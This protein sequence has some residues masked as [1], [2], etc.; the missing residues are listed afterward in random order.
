MLMMSCSRGV[1]L[2]SSERRKEEEEEEEG[3]EL[4][5]NPLFFFLPLPRPPQGDCTAHTNHQTHAA[6]VERTANHTHIYIPSA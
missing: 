5:A 6:R 2:V 4:R 1:A 3:E